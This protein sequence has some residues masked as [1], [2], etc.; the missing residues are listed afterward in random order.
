MTNNFLFWVFEINYHLGKNHFLNEKYFKT[1]SNC[2]YKLNTLF[3]NVL[4]CFPKGILEINVNIFFFHTHVAKV[5]LLI[6]VKRTII[7]KQRT[8]NLKFNVGKVSG[9]H[10]LNTNDIYL[11]VLLEQ[12]YAEKESVLHIDNTT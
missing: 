1:R 10:I 12:I 7:E 8:N 5:K 2:N 11:P 9:P 4:S 3:E 6:F